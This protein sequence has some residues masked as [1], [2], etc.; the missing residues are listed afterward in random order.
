MSRAGQTAPV[1]AANV[2][3]MEDAVPNPA[4]RNTV[5]GMACAMGASLIFSINDVSFK[6]LS[7]DFALH[8]LVLIRSSLGVIVMLSIIL[9]LNGGWGILRTKKPA[10]HFGRALLVVMSNLTYYLALAA[11]PMADGVALFYIT[12]LMITAL[13]VPMLGEKV[14]PRRW[15]AVGVGLVG[16]LVMMRPGTSAFQIAS[17]LPILSAFFYAMMHMMTRRMKGTESALTITFWVQVTFIA[18]SIL[19]GLA[20]G[21]GHLAQSTHPSLAFLFHAWTWP[22]PRD[23]AILLVVGLCSSFGGILIAQAYKLAEAAAIA[24]FEYVAMPIA[25]FWGFTVFDQ[26]PDTISWIGISL[27]CGAGLYA[28]WRE[29]VRGGRAK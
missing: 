17:V 5:M 10:L 13:S 6:F 16:V 1:A 15:A 19:M 25:V 20:V 21:D 7:G 12:P 26:W 8:E 9:P 27:I 4:R 3:G 23:W 24:P 18:V 14:G 11:L 29:A 28:F 22:P 2:A